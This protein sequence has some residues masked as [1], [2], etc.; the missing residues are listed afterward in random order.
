M[1]V[2]LVQVRRV[3]NL[4]MDGA[5]PYKIA[6]ILEAEKIDIP[7][8]HQ[9]KLGYGLHQSKVFEY[10]Y[11]RCSSTI[12]SIVNK[13]DIRSTTKKESIIK[14]RKA[15]AEETGEIKGFEKSGHTGMQNAEPFN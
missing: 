12:A 14:T 8:Y 7:A 10:P 5:G 11:R 6:K 3:F 15:R 1:S 13:K 4:T 2:E 9:Q